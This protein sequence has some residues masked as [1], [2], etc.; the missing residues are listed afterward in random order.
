MPVIVRNAR[1]SDLPELMRLGRAFYDTNQMQRYCK[2]DEDTAA[3]T[4]THL[5]QQQE[6]GNALLLVSDHVPELL[7]G[8][9][10]YPAKLGGMLALL[11]FPGYFDKSSRMVQ[12]LFWW[13]ED[14]RGI[15]LV[16]RARLWVANTG[17]GAM[18]LAETGRGDE[19]MARLYKR[20]GF[21][22][23]ERFYMA[24]VAHETSKG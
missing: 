20:L 4:L 18:M 16:N 8:G 15:E 3:L 22:P 11:S 9:K 14:G 13:A 10:E 7:E 23:V 21:E 5:I 2:F 17:G 24:Y 6:A 19:R 1:M 12:E